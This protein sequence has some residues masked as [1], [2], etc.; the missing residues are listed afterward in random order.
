MG[1]AL[2]GTLM[3]VKTLSLVFV[4]HDTSSCCRRI[5]I[6]MDGMSQHGTKHEKP[7]C[8][9]DVYLPHRSRTYAQV[10]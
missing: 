8:K 3:W 10:V 4:S 2:G 5:E 9:M 6:G 1:G 7:G